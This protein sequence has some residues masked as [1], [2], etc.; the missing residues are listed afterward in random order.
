M[1]TDPCSSVFICGFAFGCG[2][3]AL[4]N[5]YYYLENCSQ[6]DKD[7]SASSWERTHP[8]CKGRTLKARWKRALPG[9]TAAFSFLV[10]APVRCGISW[11]VKPPRIPRTKSLTTSE[12]VKGPMNGLALPIA[13][14]N[15]V[16]KC[17]RPEYMII[18][19]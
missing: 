3:T 16:L 17:E 15:S 6:P 14:E 2:S 12:T 11:P 19:H 18:A 10:A 1:N 7:F 13:P 9:T 4:C 8:V 5:S